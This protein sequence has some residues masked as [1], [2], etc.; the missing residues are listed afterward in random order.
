MWGRESVK[1]H[2]CHIIEE[3][4]LIQDAY[5]IA[6]YKPSVAVSGDGEAGDLLASVFEPLNLFVDLQSI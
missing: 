2:W 1:V 3:L 5:N 4:P 6:R